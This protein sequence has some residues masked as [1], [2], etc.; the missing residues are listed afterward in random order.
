MFRHVQTCRRWTYSTRS[1]LFAARQHLLHVELAMNYELAVIWT[2][3]EAV[4][5]SVLCLATEAD[6]QFANYA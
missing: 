5:T 4:R 6:T 2:T 1:A 3:A